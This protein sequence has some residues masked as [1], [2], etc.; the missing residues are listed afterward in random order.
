MRDYFAIFVNMKRILFALS[1]FILASCNSEKAK[2]D[3]IS[4]ITAPAGKKDGNALLNP[5][6]GA[7]G[8]RC[9][10]AVGAPLKPTSSSSEL[11]N[12]TITAPALP[13]APM[14]AANDKV[15]RLNP[16]HGAPGRRC[17][18]NVGAPLN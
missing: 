18:L 16:A 14:P 9:D 17:D 7:P 8:H 4:D 2:V 3:Q 12:P 11:P 5:A 10:V 15:V 13:K 6:H 1:F